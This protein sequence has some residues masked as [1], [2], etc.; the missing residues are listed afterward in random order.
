MYVKQLVSGGKSKI[1]N[2]QLEVLDQ[3]SHRACMYN[4]SVYTCV[5]STLTELASFQEIFLC[6]KERNGENLQVIFIL[7]ICRSIHLSIFTNE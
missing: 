6:V 5:N 1:L 4:G 7:Q 2:L 3:A